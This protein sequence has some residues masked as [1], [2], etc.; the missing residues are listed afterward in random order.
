MYYDNIFKETITRNGEFLFEIKPGDEVKGWVKT[1]HGNG[2]SGHVIANNEA[3]ES[4]VLESH[5]I[6]KLSTLLSRR[7]NFH[8]VRILKSPIYH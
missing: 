4:Q 6:S 7:S 5:S 8:L 2:K 3:Y 1:V